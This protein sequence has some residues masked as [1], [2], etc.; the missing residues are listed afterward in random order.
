MR[1]L[2][3]E[4]VDTQFL[5]NEL[6]SDTR[7]LEADAEILQ[8]AEI[9]YGLRRQLCGSRPSLPELSQVVLN[10]LGK[11]REKGGTALFPAIQDD[12]DRK[13]L[14]G[15]PYFLSILL[16][17]GLALVNESVERLDKNI[18]QQGFQFFQRLANEVNAT[19]KKNPFWA[20]LT[21]TSQRI[22]L[23]IRKKR[24]EVFQIKEKLELKN[25]ENSKLEEMIGKRVEEI[26]EIVRKEAEEVKSGSRRY[27][28]LRAG[29]IKDAVALAL[30][31]T[32]ERFVSL[33]MAN[34]ELSSDM[35]LLRMQIHLL[36][37][38]QN[39]SQ[40]DLKS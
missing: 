11:C 39:G 38:P 30:S 33:N 5:F 17:E 20:V 23:R 27:R 35:E 4:Q 26:R 40:A 16:N 28:K 29:L 7:Q 19:E 2:T 31:R 37:H 6:I 24:K 10:L 3:D 36:G 14:N 25:R 1:S 13:V 8:Q 34:Q 15:S 22:R 21:L 32:Q 12:F 18:W 9:F